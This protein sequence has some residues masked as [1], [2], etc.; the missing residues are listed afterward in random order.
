M[1]P[2]PYT[3]FVRLKMIELRKTKALSQQGFGEV[4]GLSATNISALELAK[5]EWSLTHMSTAIVRFDLP[6]SFFNV[7]EQPADGGT[8]A[9][10]KQST[11]LLHKIAGLP[12]AGKSALYKYSL[13]DGERRDIIDKMIAA[14]QHADLAVFRAVL[15]LLR[16]AFK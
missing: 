10:L 15:A 1:K 8:V 16:Q 3:E 14:A 12:A 13:L 9:E 11:M 6:R 7:E 2:L 4:L 5:H